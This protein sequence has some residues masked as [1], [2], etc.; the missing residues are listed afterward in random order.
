MW[1]NKT[2]RRRS[3]IPMDIDKGYLVAVP[4]KVT[5]ARCGIEFDKTGVTDFVMEAGVEIDIRVEKVAVR[6]G[7]W[8]WNAGPSGVAKGT[9]TGRWEGP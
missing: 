3:A 7:K 6:D 8:S 5:A 1:C 2:G 9:S 4:V